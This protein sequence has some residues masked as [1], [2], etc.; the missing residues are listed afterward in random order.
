ME[1][2]VIRDV[3]EESNARA[4]ENR[5]LFDRHGV[6]VVNMMSSPGAGK[7]TLLQKSIPLLQARGRKCA[8]IE[9]DITSTL[10][11]EK[12]SPLGIPVVQANTEPFGGDCHIGSHLV[13]AALPHFDLANTDILFIEN[14]GNL[15]CPAE[16]YLGED[17]KVVVLSITEGEDK[18]LKYPLMFRECQLCLLS[19]MDLAP[20]LDVNVD[21]IK[22]NI[23]R[24]NAQLEVIPVSARTGV[25]IEEWV[26]WLAKSRST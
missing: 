3:L 24:T 15:V 18:P 7:T 1:I 17:R 12:L 14:I 2:P 22:E 23:R 9:G 10:D 6:F 25:G 13:Q 5:K 20:H 4:E 21:Q 19:K 8:V 16:F 26:E 11:S